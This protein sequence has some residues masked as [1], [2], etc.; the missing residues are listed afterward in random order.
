MT[1]SHGF[2]DLGLSLATSEFGIV[3]VGVTDGSPAGLSD[4]KVGD[5]LVQVRKRVLRSF[6]GPCFAFAAQWLVA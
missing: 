1:C 3:V 6:A 4:V 5:Y 2:D